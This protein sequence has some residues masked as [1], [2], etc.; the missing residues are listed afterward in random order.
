MSKKSSFNNK[1]KKPAQ[2]V[3]SGKKKQLREK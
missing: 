3:W 2:V 1:K